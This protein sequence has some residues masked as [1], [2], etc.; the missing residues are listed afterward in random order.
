ML[1]HRIRLTDV[2]SFGPSFQELKLEPLNVLIG[3]NGAGKSN[4][5]EAIGLLKAA[6]RDL[7][8]PIR[9]GGGVHD[10]IRRGEATG[11][12]AQVEV[13]LP[14]GPNR[15][16]R[17]SLAFRE[18]NQRFR[19]N[20]EELRLEY[21]DSGASD[22]YV[23]THGTRA[24]VVSV[25]LESDNNAGRHRSGKSAG[26]LAGWLEKYSLGDYW[27]RGGLGGTRW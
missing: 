21:P 5:I 18:E 23:T 20:A 11:G 26:E 2:L 19:V 16:L 15:L 17:Y 27:M 13:V 3:P 4:L 25:D 10:W 8:A 7:Y 6:P 1:I 12:I 14:Y 24:R 22:P 9:E